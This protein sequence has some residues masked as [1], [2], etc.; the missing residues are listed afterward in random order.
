ML[1]IL[2][3]FWL[4]VNFS[5]LRSMPTKPR[6]P[7]IPWKR[8]QEVILP[9]KYKSKSSSPWSVRMKNEEGESV[10]NKRTS[11][12]H[13]NLNFNDSWIQMV[14]QWGTRALVTKPESFQ[15]PS[16]PPMWGGAQERHQEGWSGREDQG[17]DEAEI[18][19]HQVVL[20]SLVKA[21]LLLRNSPETAPNP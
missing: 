9:R 6:T 3:P 19:I 17:G 14:K 16:N 2:A 11:L 15:T 12:R 1:R 18:H 4:A 13:R 7:T 21:T 5:H 8:C 20:T 10:Q